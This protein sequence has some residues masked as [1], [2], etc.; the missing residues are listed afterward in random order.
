MTSAAIAIGWR[1]TALLRRFGLAREAVA[2]VE[3]ALVMPFMLT[4]YLGSMELSQLISV[5]QRVTNIAGTIGDLAAR[6][7]G[8]LAD[9]DMQNYFA[10]ASTVIAPFTTDGLAQ[11]VT[12]VQVDKDGKTTVI[13]SVGYNGG[14]PRSCKEPFPGPHAIPPSMIAISKNNYV[15]VSEAS[16]SY[17]PLLGLFFKHP[18]SLYHENFYLPRFAAAINYS[19]TPC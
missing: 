19:P 4:L 18:F 16:Y 8:T 2:A 7:D 13:W 10:A 12:E 14:S 3:F 15:I 6:A 5:D 11:V 9:T 1:A 17:Q